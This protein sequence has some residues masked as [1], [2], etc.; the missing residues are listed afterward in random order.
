MWQL[1]YNPQHYFNWY[2]V[3]TRVISQ[4]W[5]WSP[6]PLERSTSLGEMTQFTVIEPWSIGWLVNCHITTPLDIVAC[7]PP[8]IMDPMNY[9][10]RSCLAPPSN[11]DPIISVERSEASCKVTWPDRMSIYSLRQWLANRLAASKLSAA[12]YRMKLHTLLLSASFVEFTSDY[13]FPR[14]LSQRP[15]PRH[16]AWSSEFRA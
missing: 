5:Q 6:L 12:I 4:S 2:T 15:S 1:N 13:V 11:I 3:M 8:W 9:P 16:R 10:L 14:R 7:L